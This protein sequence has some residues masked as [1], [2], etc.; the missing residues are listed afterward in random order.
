MVLPNKYLPI[1]ES[2]I[3]LSALLLDIIGNKQFTIDKLWELFTKKYIDKNKI[4][5]SPTYQKYIYVVEFMYICGFINYNID[6]EV[7][8]EN[9]RVNN[10][11]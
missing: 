9:I 8:N 1:S 5:V 6:G 7:Y 3:G 11:R 10:K 4:K 2:L